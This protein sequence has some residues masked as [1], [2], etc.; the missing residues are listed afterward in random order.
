MSAIPESTCLLLLINAAAQN[1]SQ[2][3]HSNAELYK[4]L[5]EILGD[6]TYSFIML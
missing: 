1:D 4:V 5:L 2:P 6:V 3:R